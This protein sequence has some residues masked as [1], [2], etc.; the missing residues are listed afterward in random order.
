LRGK[1]FGVRALGAGQW[2][3][4]IVALERL[5]LASKRDNI[6]TLAIGDQTQITRALEAGTIDAAVLSPAQS[7]RF[8]TRGFPVLLDLY[9]ADIYGYPNALAVTATYLRQSPD[10]MEKVVAALI[11]SMAFS[12]LPANEST[13]L[14]TIMNTFRIT[15]PVAAEEGYQEFLLTAM[16]KPYPCVE[17]LRNMQNVMAL[18][19]P[20]VSS[21]QIEDLIEDRFVRKLDASGLIDRLYGSDTA[22][23][24]SSG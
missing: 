17:R 6:S 21:V 24:R 16:R 23:L 9:P 14:H 1:R 22:T 13:V 2:I 5:G 18:H 10:V 8:R 7:R 11:E 19:D 20:K 15:D 3:Q 4:T 12:L